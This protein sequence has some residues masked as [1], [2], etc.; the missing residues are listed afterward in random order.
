MVAFDIVNHL[1]DRTIILVGVVEHHR[2]T[3][4]NHREPLPVGMFLCGE[5]AENRVF[6]ICQ[7]A[8]C[9]WGNGL[10]VVL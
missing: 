6:R 4:L 1:Y 9:A 7:N 5:V 10:L 3:G 8:Q 2:M